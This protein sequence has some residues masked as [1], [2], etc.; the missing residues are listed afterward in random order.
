MPSAIPSPEFCTALNTRSTSYAWDVHGNDA[1]EVDIRA[2]AENPHF[3]QNLIVN[4]RHAD[5]RPNNAL[6]I[7]MGAPVGRYV[8]KGII[9]S[10]AIEVGEFRLV[11]VTLDKEATE[12][13]LDYTGPQ[14]NINGHFPQQAFEEVNPIVLAQLRNIANLRPAS[15]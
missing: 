13:L 11:M 2:W 8:A 5:I 3:V 9:K 4:S 7:Y 14:P 1:S 15:R 12:N 10:H 6:W